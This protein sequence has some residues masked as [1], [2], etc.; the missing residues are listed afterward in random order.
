ML[1]T[2]ARARDATRQGKKKKEAK[3][4]KQKKMKDKRK[5]EES[6]EVDG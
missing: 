5:W 1:E 2:F 4:G 6:L 3:G